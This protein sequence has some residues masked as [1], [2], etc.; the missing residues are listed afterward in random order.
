MLA[1]PGLRSFSLAW[2]RSSSGLSCGEDGLFVG[3]VALLKSLRTFGKSHWTVRPIHELNHDLTALYR[4]P[5]DA[6]AKT[7]ALTLVAAAFDRND[8]ATAA[9][10]A[11]QMRFPDPPA[12]RKGGEGPHQLTRRAEA[13]FRSGLLKFWDPAK[14]PRT[15]TPPNPGRFAPVDGGSQSAEVVPVAMPNKPP[16][17]K[18]FIWEGGGGEAHPAVN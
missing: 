5:V 9:I 7:N 10:A 11:V 2:R 14:H 4:L 18:P 13:L 1:I 3:H 8:L 12:L 6:T 16:W 17:D 15:G